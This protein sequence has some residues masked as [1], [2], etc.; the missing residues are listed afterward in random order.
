[1]LKE[2]V[3]GRVWPAPHQLPARA[4]EQH[5]RAVLPG[6]AAGG[7]AVAGHDEQAAVR[8]APQPRHGREIVDAVDV[9]IHRQ[10]GGLDAVREA[11]APPGLE[12]GRVQGPEGGIG[13]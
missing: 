4:D 2:R 10:G 12:G 7:P 1:M 8:Q 3:G 6:A 13:G 5:L 11:E 9:A